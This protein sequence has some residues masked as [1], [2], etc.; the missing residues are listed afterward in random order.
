MVSYSQTIVQTSALNI[1][2][3]QNMVVQARVHV[4]WYVTFRLSEGHNVTR[5]HD[6]AAYVL[7]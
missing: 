7:D 5:P 2:I 4:E 6:Q 3:G 1:L